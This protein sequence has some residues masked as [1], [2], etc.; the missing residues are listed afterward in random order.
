M[1]VGFQVLEIN[2]DQAV[3]LAYGVTMHLIYYVPTI[4]IGL[5]WAF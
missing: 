3:A 1:I 4:I 5:I 2:E